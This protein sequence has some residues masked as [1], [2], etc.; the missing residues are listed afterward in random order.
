MAQNGHVVDLGCV[1]ELFRDE[2][3]KV[4][5]KLSHNI[6]GDKLGFIQ[7]QAAID[8]IKLAMNDENSITASQA[9]ETSSSPENG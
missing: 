5:R 1:L 4:V 7:L 2:R 3:R 9:R 6:M 8:A